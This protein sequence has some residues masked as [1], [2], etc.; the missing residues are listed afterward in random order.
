MSTNSPKFV[1]ETNTFH[2]AILKPF[3]TAGRMLDWDK[4]AGAPG[5]GFTTELIDEILSRD[6]HLCCY[7]I[8]HEK[9]LWLNADIIRGFKSTN[10]T[11]GHNGTRPIIYLPITLFCNERQPMDAKLF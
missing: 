5:I 9:T 4:E 7:L 11:E 8:E 2:V 6:S 10:N 1:P 3:Y